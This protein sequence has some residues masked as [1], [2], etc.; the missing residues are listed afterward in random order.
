MQPFNPIVCMLGVGRYCGPHCGPSAAVHSF[1]RVT[2]GYFSAVCFLHGRALLRDTGRPQGLIESC[3]GGTPIESWTIWDS[4]CNASRDSVDSTDSVDSVDTVGT[5]SDSAAGTGTGTGLLA[6]GDG[7]GMDERGAA[8]SLYNG[9]IAPLLEFPIKGVVWYQGESNSKPKGADPYACQMREMIKGWRGAWKNPPTL[10]NF[11][12]ILHQLSAYSG[13][14]RALRWSQQ[15]AVP[16]WS[17]LAKVGM[18]VGLDLSDPTSPCGN[19]H[20]RNKSAVGE[21]MALAARALGYG[22]NVSYT[23][24]VAKSFKFSTA[25]ELVVTYSGAAPPLE[26]RTIAQTTSPTQGFEMLHATFDSYYA[27]SASRTSVHG[28]S[29]V[30]Q[31]SYAW[32]HDGGAD[33]TASGRRHLHAWWVGTARPVSLAPNMRD[34]PPS[35]P[36]YINVVGMC[37][38]VRC[39]A[40]EN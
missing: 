14:N 31:V 21:R 37:E 27:D 8:G 25:P 34:P 12:F 30:S 3:W 10:K 1:K 6:H 19:V 15:G 18:T 7:D 11:T 28:R 36:D 4:N 35:R 16:P 39:N 40:L 33:T 13:E 5:G 17:G 38:T 24:P 32:R 9:M 26:F 22:A 23:G 20:I 2:W 29:F